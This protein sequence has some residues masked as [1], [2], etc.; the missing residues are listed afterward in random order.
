MRLAYWRITTAQVSWY[1]LSVSEAILGCASVISL[2][3]TYQ[4]ERP[5]LF[6]LIE[7]SLSLE[8]SPS[9]PNPSSFVNAKK[10]PCQTLLLYTVK[11]YPSSSI[12][13]SMQVTR[14]AQHFISAAPSQVR[15]L[16]LTP[17]QQHPVQA[18][19]RCLKFP[20]LGLTESWKQQVYIYI[21]IYILFT[22]HNNMYNLIKGLYRSITF[23]RLI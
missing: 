21:C 23:L 7:V 4:L 2:H 22:F 6:Q 20:L 18:E 3:G 15:S 19:L 16:S 8:F 14:T 12:A 13:V 1:A 11:L 5:L 17:F 9:D 10:F